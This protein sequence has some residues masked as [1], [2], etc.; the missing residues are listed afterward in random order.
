MTDQQYIIRD[1]SQLDSIIGDAP[2]FLRAKVVESLDESMIEFIQRAPLVFLSTEDANGGLDVSPKGD[3]PGFVQ[4]NEAGQLLIP[5][6]PGNKLTFGFR[7]IL[8]NPQLGLIF[9]VPNTRETLRVKGRATLSNDPQLLEQLQAQ[10]KPALLCTKVD[11]DECFFHCGKAMIRSK[12]WQPEE[13]AEPSASLMVRH[14]TKVIAN[15]SSL[16]PVIEQEIERTY[17][18]ELY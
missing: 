3:A 12:M 9:V 7:N 13:W 14:T 15:D 1:E 10:N 18:E 5:E 17:R 8:R 2:E 6:R 16:E 4:I 11:V